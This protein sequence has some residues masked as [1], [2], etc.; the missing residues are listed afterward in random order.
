MVKR[1]F[2]LLPVLF[3]LLWGLEK[4]YDYFLLKNVNLKGSYVME[5]K[6]D[7]DV[8]FLGPCEPLWMMDPESFKK[9]AGM[10]AYN[11]AT[12][13]ANFAEN[14]AM[15]HLYL[16]HNRPPHYLFLYVTTESMDG[17]FN[18]FNTYSFSQFYSDPYISEQV[19]K[20]D[21]GYAKWTVIPFMKYAYYNDF[22]N[23]NMLQGIKHVL[24]ERKV[25]Y[26]PDGFVRPHGIAWDGRLEHFIKEYPHGRHFSWNQDEVRDLQ[27]L[28]DLARGK[29]IQVILYESP[30]LD[31]IKPF[32][33]NRDEIKQKITKFAGSNGI[34][35]WVF[36]TM[37]ISKSR[38]CFFSILNTN[39]QGS[40]VFNQTFAR[41]FLATVK[42][43]DSRK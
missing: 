16:L 12:V 11:L 36:D 28:L 29:G 32:I 3:L 35:Y 31:E 10:K 8:L 19:Q 33:L 2:F 25:P 22:V 23:F 21:P 40:A 5:Q 18:V 17:G 27:T 7:A 26:F 9:L 42:Q 13:H 34:P 43:A 39:D 30:M 24:T 20:E 41:Y 6:V 38:S 14:E 37:Q 15:L 4:C 1:M